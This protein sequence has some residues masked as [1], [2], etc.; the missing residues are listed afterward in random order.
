LEH[1]FTDLLEIQQASVLVDGIANNQSTLKPCNCDNNNFAKFRRIPMADKGSSSTLKPLFITTGLLAVS[2]VMVVSY[3]TFSPSSEAPDTAIHN[4][5]NASTPSAA[6]SSSTNASALPTELKNG[7]TESQLLAMLP[8]AAADDDTAVQDRQPLTLW[9]AGQKSPLVE[10]GELRVEQV[11]ANPDYLEQLE[12]GRKVE[13]VIPHT[14][15]SVA[16]EIAGQDLTNNGITTYDLKL[17]DNNPLTG[18][19]AVRGKISTDFVV[20]T[21]SGNY[22]I[23]INNKTGAGQVIDDRD[24]HI[25]RKHPDAIPVATGTPPKPTS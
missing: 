5:Q 4:N 2:T 16:G 12:V 7:I 18:G 9:Q 3:L 1:L 11:I 15:E 6:V 22:T 19:H 17:N 8:K 25:Y 21:D 10:P 14:G 23:S 20:V 13:F 24:L